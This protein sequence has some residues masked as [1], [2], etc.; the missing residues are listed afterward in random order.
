MPKRI[1]ALLLTVLASTLA[2]PYDVAVAKPPPGLCTNADAALPVIRQLPWAQQILDPARVWPYST[3]AGVLVAVVDS[4]VDSDHPQLRRPGK[5]AA[6]EDFFQVGRL[7]A[8]FDC[9]SHGTAVAGIIA[10][11]AAAGIGFRGIAPQA[12]I[13]PVRVSERG[14]TDGT[15]NEIDPLVLAQGIRYAADQ[16]ADVINLSLA[17]ARDD[18]V[19]RQAV[20]Y[21]QRKDVLVIAAVGNGQRDDTI[22]PSYP[23]AYPGV[24]GV[25][26]TDIAGTRLQ[27]SQIGPYVDLMAPGG[28]VVGA[29]RSG[30]HNYYSGTSF[31]VPFVAGT[32][33][34]VRAAW[35]NL[36]APQVAQ[37]LLATTMPARGG[38]SRAAYGVGIVDPYRAVTDGL[39]TKRPAV[40]PTMA[41][42]PVDEVAAAR[43]AGEQR[44]MSRAWHGSGLVIAAALLALLV[45][46][47]VPQ[48]VRRRWRPGRTPEPATEPIRDE[49]P[50]QLFL[51]PPPPAER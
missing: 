50:D 43:T 18:K 27:S 14:S 22:R 3:G 2:T 8:N 24:L 44:L 29:A 42:P 25:G 9:D 17:G 28:S 12:R 16:G 23:A 5:V 1:T 51:L 35:P 13:L 39:T 40:M 47:I 38:S 46:L 41:H 49:A 48:A 26:A 37:R 36:T 45:A 32:A 33:A 7:R 34:L 6:G 15:A 21:A 11:D 4:G 31:A 20:A 19:V 10:A 30:G